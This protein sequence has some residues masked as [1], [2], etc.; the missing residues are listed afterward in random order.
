M[1][2]PTGLQYTLVGFAPDL[3]WRPL[4][5]VKPIPPIKICSA[6]GLVRKRIALLPCMHV[7]CE[8]CFMQCAQDGSHFCPHDGRQC[9]EEDVDWKESVVYEMLRA[10]VTCWN[11]DCGCE[12]VMTASEI[13]RHFRL[14]CGHHYISC[15]KCSVRVLSSDVYLHLTTVCDV[16]GKSPESEDK[17]EATSQ[18]E[19]SLSTSFGADFIK[20]AAEIRG[21]LQRIAAANTTY[22]DRLNNISQGLNELKETMRVQMAAETMKICDSLTRSMHDLNV[23]NL[24]VKKCMTAQSVAGINLSDTIGGLEKKIGDEISNATCRT[25]DH[26]TQTATDIKSEGKEHN[27][28]ALEK[29]TEVIRRAER[30]VTVANLCIRCVNALRKRA[31]KQGH[32]AYCQQPLYLRGYLLSPL[33]FFEKHG[34]FFRLHAG[35]KVCKGKMDDS[36]EWPLAITIRLSVIR[37]KDCA[38]REFQISGSGSE[39]Q[40]QKPIDECNLPIFFPKQY[41][42]L[43]D[44]VNDG[45]VHDDTLFIEWE[46]LL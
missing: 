22:D 20:Q 1:M 42:N 36:V 31:L 6:C 15:P 21:F 39:Q 2:L 5:F 3:D 44:L 23:H 37:P 14:E 11:K 7:L 45:Y 29:M 10:E 12:V 43:H 18:D 27:E 46:L 40:C 28:R 38:K 24:E 26:V 32:A 16:E 13:S 9:Q 41:L 25:V 30:Q 19:A 34:E 33:I 8:S 17:V 35:V 4:Q